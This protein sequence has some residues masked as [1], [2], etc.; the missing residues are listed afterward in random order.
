MDGLPPNAVIYLPVLQAEIR[1]HWPQ[2]PLPSTLAAQVEQET[3]YHLKHKK[4]WNP[5]AELKTEREYGFGL[6]QLTVTKRF[7]NFAE[8]KKLHS[9]LAS[10][11]W[12]ERY[13]PARQL[14]TMVLMDK[15]AWLRLSFVDDEIER[16][17]MTFSAY[18]G[19]LGGVL[20]DRKLCASVA[21]CNPN[22]WFGHV[23]DYSFK[24]KTKTSG[25]GQSFYDINREYV[26]NVL[27]T[28][29][30]KYAAYFGD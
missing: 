6:G 28:R 10:W 26:V 14:R 11:Q 3:C 4:C 13:D 12:E 27:T 8:A 23:A 15:A 17:A 30:A 18:N 7:D 29:R 16:L 2:A 1:T 21:G 20:Q 22:L 9:T 24:K 19:G 25:Y 5:R